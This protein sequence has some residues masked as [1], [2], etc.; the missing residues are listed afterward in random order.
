MRFRFRLEKLLDSRRIQQEIAQKIFTEAKYAVDLEARKLQELYDQEKDSYKRLAQAQIQGGQ[1]TSVM[2]N[3]FVY[4][5]G[6]KINIEKQLKQIQSL[7]S[8]VEEK[9]EILQQRMIEYKI[10]EKLK[11]KRYQQFLQEVRTQE[12]RELD[13][14]S[15]LRYSHKDVE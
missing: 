5:T 3:I 12:Q 1:Q 11:E 10:I 9:R 14:V 7:Q 8:V 2:Q 15:V 13:E 4:Q 6:L